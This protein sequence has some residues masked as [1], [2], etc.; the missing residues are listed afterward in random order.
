MPARKRGGS[1][2]S[3]LIPFSKRPTIPIDANHRLVL[4]AEEIDCTDLL[5]FVEEIRMNKVKNAAG[6]PPHVRASGR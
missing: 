6:R 4:L 1:R 2:Q 5:G 3:Q